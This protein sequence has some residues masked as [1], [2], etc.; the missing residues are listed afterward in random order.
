LLLAFSLQGF[1]LLLLKAEK[2]EQARTAVQ[3]AVER[4]RTLVREAPSFPHAEWALAFALLQLCAC[5]ELEEKR[6]E[7]LETAQDAV[8]MCRQYGDGRSGI[9][10]TFLVL[11]LRAVAHF[12]TR[13]GRPDEAS[14]ATREAMVLQ[15]R[16]GLKLQ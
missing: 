4:Y 6:E 5:L 15:E 10:L 16:F 11:S 13:L 9:G 3:G 8:R 7:G 1:S 14:E 12:L 2:K